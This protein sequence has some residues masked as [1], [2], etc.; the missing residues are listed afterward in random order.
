LPQ[1]RVDE[2]INF[3]N[4]NELGR[5]I[6]NYHKI[7]D[8]QSNDLKAN[9]PN[10][11]GYIFLLFFL[12]YLYLTCVLIWWILSSIQKSR[13][14]NKISELV[15]KNFSE[16]IQFKNETLL[17]G[18]DLL[19]PHLKRPD[20]EIINTASNDIKELFDLRDKVLLFHNKSFLTKS[21]YKFLMEVIDN[22]V[23]KLRKLVSNA[24]N[25]LIEGNN[26]L[27]KKKVLNNFLNS[28]FINRTDYEW[29]IEKWEKNTIRIGTEERLMVLIGENNLDTEEEI[30]GYIAEGRLEE[31]INRTYN[32]I[33]NSYNLSEGVKAADENERIITISAR[34]KTIEKDYQNRTLAQNDYFIEINKIRDSLLALIKDAAKNGVIPKNSKKS[35]KDNNQTN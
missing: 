32:I 4:T 14:F 22:I 26:F 17:N 12:L 33:S 8:T 27:V 31:A 9:M 7:I 6:A 21:N 24:L 35:N 23:N 5:K 20:I 28:E 30:T 34:F 1:L 29:L 18:A 19:V 10:S 3:F 13:L 25:S 15:S 16:T 2:L 11:K